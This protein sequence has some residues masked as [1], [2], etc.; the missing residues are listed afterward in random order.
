MLKILWTDK[1]TNKDVL[2]T[3]EE[4]K[5][6]LVETLQKRRDI[7]IGHQLKHGSL[8]KTIIEDTGKGKL[9]P[10]L[11]YTNQILEDRS[12]H[13]YSTMKRLAEDC[14]AWRAAETIPGMRTTEKKIFALQRKPF[15]ELL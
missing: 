15:P 9:R 8:F 7:W 2:M 11:E 4:S 5:A 14:E 3:M 10:K 13:R 1:L 6:W 12:C